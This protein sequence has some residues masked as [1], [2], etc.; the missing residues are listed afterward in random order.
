MTIHRHHS[1]DPMAALGE[2]QCEL[3]S[4]I[5]KATRFRKPAGRGGALRVWKHVCFAFGI[6]GEGVRGRIIRRK[7]KEIAT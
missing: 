1:H 3:V 6:N 7:G 4:D 5:R 2:G